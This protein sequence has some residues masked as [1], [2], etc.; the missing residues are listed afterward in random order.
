MLDNR[1]QPWVQVFQAGEYEDDLPL[2]SA[3]STGDWNA[4]GE[5]GSGD[6]VKAF[7]DGGYEIDATPAIASVPE[8]SGLALLILGA[9]CQWL[10]YRRVRFRVNRHHV[11]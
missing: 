10:S 2:N 6:L 11:P 5:F 8:A 3:W 9:G 7:Q 4:D 1:L